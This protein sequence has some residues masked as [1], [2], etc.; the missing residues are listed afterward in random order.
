MCAW[1]IDN[2][3]NSAQREEWIPQLAS[4]EKFASYCLTEPGS[5]S[6]AASL[7]TTARRSGDDLILNGSKV[8]IFLLIF[9]RPF[10]PVQGSS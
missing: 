10:W 2:F 8:S 5:G 4:M 3:G 6:D 7:S 1:M 9:A